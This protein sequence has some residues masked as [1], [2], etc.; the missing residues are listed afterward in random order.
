[1]IRCFAGCAGLALW[2]SLSAAADSAQLSFG[3]AWSA[4][5]G[6]PASGFGWLVF[7][8]GDVNDNGDGD[9]SDVSAGGRNEEQ[10]RQHAPM[11]HGGRCASASPCRAGKGLAKELAPRRL[12]E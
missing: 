2:F 8:A 9:V 4:V 5:S 3:S 6:Q 1:M 7:S 10:G 12:G 11:H